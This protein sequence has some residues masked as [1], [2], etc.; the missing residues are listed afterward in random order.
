MEDPHPVPLVANGQ[1]WQA[2]ELV[3]DEAALIGQ[4][5]RMSQQQRRT[6]KDALQL[7]VQPLLA[8][9]IAGR[10]PKIHRLR[11]SR[12]VVE[13]ADQAAQKITLDNALQ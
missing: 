11:F 7:R 4:L 13:Q 5:G 3:P 9:I 12:R 1:Q 2:G 10:D 6:S 8:N